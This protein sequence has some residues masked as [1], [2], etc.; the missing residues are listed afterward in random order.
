MRLLAI[1]DPE[2]AETLFHVFVSR[3]VNQVL[4]LKDTFQTFRV[5]VLG[6]SDLDDAHYLHGDK[7]VTFS[8]K[9]GLWV[10]YGFEHLGGPELIEPYEVIMTVL[11]DKP[12]NCVDPKIDLVP[13][14]A[15]Y[16]KQ[17]PYLP[18]PGCFN[19]HDGSPAMMEAMLQSW[20]ERIKPRTVTIQ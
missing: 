6:T 9:K 1:N 20:R 2:H 11:D 17:S 18:H 8:P 5:H 7:V 16:T 4:K 19:I 3:Y 10:S 14:R 12:E 15:E 13:E